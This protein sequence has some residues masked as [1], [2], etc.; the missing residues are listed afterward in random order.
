MADAKINESCIIGLPTCGYAFSSSRMAFIA[1]PADEEFSLELDVLKNLLAEKDYESY[2]ALQQLAPAKLAFCTKICSKI[3]TSQ[4]CIVLLNSSSH[5]KNPKIKIPNPNVHLEYGLMLA[6]KKYILPFQRE[7]DAL[8]FNIKPLDTILYKK[9]NFK[10]LANSA[11]DEAIIRTG[12][13]S[14]PTRALTS[15]DILLR[16]ASVLGLRVT[17]LNT[18]EANYLYKLG[19]PMGF[20]LLDGPDIV[21]LGLF[22]LEPAK[23]VVFRLKLLLQALHNAKHQFETVMRKNMTPEQ[24]DKVN[25]IWN[26]LRVEVLVSKEVDKEKVSKKVTDL[27]KSFETVPW[28]LVD[29]NDIRLVIERA[30]DDI[31]EI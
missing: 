4:F 16:Y 28:K 22:D 2:I 20:L 8:A 9:N 13:T 30:Y 7:G 11:I 21:Y 15:S 25:R 6:F 24:I 27:V 12:T 10:D 1:T 17:Q 14:R 23:E 31:G 5:K 26:Q 3:I 19:Q 29:E 18:D